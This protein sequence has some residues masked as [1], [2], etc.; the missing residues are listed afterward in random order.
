MRKIFTLLVM[1]ISLGLTSVQ[2]NENQPQGIDLGEYAFGIP[3]NQ[4]NFTNQTPRLILFTIKKTYIQAKLS[5][6]LLETTVSRFPK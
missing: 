2:A 6:R 1:L 3:T 5:K 4:L